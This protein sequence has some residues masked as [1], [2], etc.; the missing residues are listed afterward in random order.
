[1]FSL[2]VAQFDKTNI[3]YTQRARG[4]QS[5]QPT[6]S[7]TPYWLICVVIIYTVLTLALLLAQMPLPPLLHCHCIHTL[8]HLRV[9]RK[10]NK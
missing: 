5:K 8:S 10:N 3:Q 7:F 4:F 1:M 9:V 2:F 6:N